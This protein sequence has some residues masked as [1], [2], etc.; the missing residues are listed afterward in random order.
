[1]R[2]SISAAALAA[3]AVLWAPLSGCSS[4]D[5]STVGALNITVTTSGELPDPDGYTITIN[6]RPSQAIGVNGTLNVTSLAEGSYTVTLAG[7]SDQCFSSGDDPVVTT[8]AGGATRDVHFDVSCP[9]G[10]SKVAVEVLVTGADPDT[11]GYMLKI[12]AEDPRRVHP[13]GTTT[14]PSG[15]H[16]HPAARVERCC[17]QLHA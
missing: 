7:M 17:G 11:N 8:V 6:D 16:R 1:M 12:G 15:T 10:G 5:E 3:I 2:S 4:D 9:A 14:L 13:E